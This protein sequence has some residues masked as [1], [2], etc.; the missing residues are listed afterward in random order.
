MK[1]QLLAGKDMIIG[2]LHWPDNFS[3]A[4]LTDRALKALGSYYKAVGQRMVLRPQ[5]K[6]AP[7]E[8]RVFSYDGTEVRRWTIVDLAKARGKHPP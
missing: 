5:Y 8:I 1:V 4:D 2:E 6:V 7:S 3:D